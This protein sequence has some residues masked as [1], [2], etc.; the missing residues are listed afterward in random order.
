M[1]YYYT[2]NRYRNNLQFKRVNANVSFV[3]LFI[4]VNFRSNI[5]YSKKA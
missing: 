4:V 2:T 3:I 5:F 1:V